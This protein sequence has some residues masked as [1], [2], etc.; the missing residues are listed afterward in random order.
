MNSIWTVSLALIVAADYTAPGRHPALEPV[1]DR[2]AATSHVTIARVRIIET[3][4]VEPYE[5]IDGENSYKSGLPKVEYEPGRYKSR[6]QV[7]EVPAG[8]KALEQAEIEIGPYDTREYT[9]FH[10]GDVAVDP[11][12]EPGE[13]IL[14]PLFRETFAP[15]PPLRWHS[16][17]WNYFASRRPAHARPGTTTYE[18]DS[19][20]LL[21][22]ARFLGA[23]GEQQWDIIRGF[24]LGNDR[25]LSSW[26][27]GTVVNEIR[28]AGA[29]S[30]NGRRGLD[31]LRT[32]ISGPID[33]M[34]EFSRSHL[35]SG[36]ATEKA[37]REELR[38]ER[39]KFIEALAAMDYDGAVE[40]RHVAGQIANTVDMGAHA[41]DD[42]ETRRQ[43]LNRYAM[44]LANR[45]LAMEQRVELVRALGDNKQRFVRFTDHDVVIVLTDL[46]ARTDEEA[47]EIAAAE[48]L[49]DGVQVDQAG[50]NAIR[51][52]LSEVQSIEAKVIVL[53]ILDS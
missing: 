9:S 40:A 2:F 1:N 22:I 27:I 10:L 49:R 17:A 43:L 36:L 15:G 34:S 13:E 41:G 46:L 14:I 6:V 28:L 50:Q 44:V 29:N 3:A 38:E 53:S 35:V 7:L 20:F 45:S 37:L 8:E 26:A 32:I 48:T 51:G 42:Q 19:A 24:A 39:L 30:E 52:V 21:E 25:K 12:L 16:S 23:S 31:L 5:R 47:I 11:P 33:R 18:E 4:H